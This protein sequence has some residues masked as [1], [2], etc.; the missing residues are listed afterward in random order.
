MVG[1]ELCVFL[2]RGRFEQRDRVGD[3]ARGLVGGGEVVAGSEGMRMV[4][5]ELR[6]EVF[7]RRLEHRDP[8]CG[9]AQPTR[10]YAAARLLRV[11]SES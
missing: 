9:A 6:L 4:G 10:P 2:F 11:T 3:P 8:L 1:P 5:P 7:E